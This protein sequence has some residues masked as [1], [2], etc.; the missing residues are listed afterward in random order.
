[1][2][3]LHIA[4]TLVAGLALAAC[5]N[6]SP[7]FVDSIPDNAIAVLSLHPMQIH[8]KG[9]LNSF[10]GLK[11]KA[12]DE[13]WSMILEDPLST[14]LM[15]D[16]YTYMFAWMEEEAPVM[17]MVAGMKDKEKFET[18]LLKIGEEVVEGFVD[19][20][21][22][23]YVQP[24][25]EGIIAWNEEQVVILGSTD[26]DEF[27]ESFWTAKLDWMFNPVKE[28]SI[29]SLVDFKDFQGKMKDM[30]MWFSTDDLQKIMKI[31]A[32]ERGSG[33]KGESLGDF[34]INLYNNYTHL[35]CDFANGAV[36]ITGE[37][38]FSEEVQ[39][40][41]D[42]ILVLN[43]SLNENALQ[44]A[45]GEDLL[46]AMAVS[47]D[48]EKARKLMDRIPME[49]LPEGPGEIKENMEEAIGVEM[50]TLLKALTGDFTLAVNGI[51]GEAMI[52]LEIFIGVGVKSDEIQKELMKKIEDMVPIEEEGD[53]FVINI[54][55]N[56]IYS[57]ILEDT[58]VLTNKKG[59]KDAVKGGKLDKSLLDSKFSEFA[60][61]SAGMYLNL[62]LDAYPSLVKDI[63][64][65][66]EKREQWINQLT[67]PL[68]YVGMMAG[69]RQGKM[70]LKTNEP[71]ENSLYTLL[72]MAEHGE[73]SND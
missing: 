5:N 48:L 22:Y 69:D 43:P 6:K 72:K 40:N 25:D 50:E 29:T 65:Q 46:M 28:E 23:Q 14:G 26:A 15:L 18:L 34:P 54:Q 62:D 36:N 64:S 13:V 59:Y 45:P 39:K 41:L 30:N 56:E 9:K 52:P 10:E 42:E 20:E 32:E 3:R 33:D 12:K 63:A 19:K 16:E 35:Y 2:K 70:T 67:D 8:K 55:G 49:N 7:Q 71:G 61:G 27:E 11:E 51:E 31:I 21:G 4:L 57:G 37:T 60:G 38:N 73:D 66:D 58:W 68:D 17:G 44:M 1:M 24:D 47:M 53:F